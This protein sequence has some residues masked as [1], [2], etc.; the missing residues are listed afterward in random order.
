MGNGRKQRSNSHNRGGGTLTS[1]EERFEEDQ[2][3]FFV[4]AEIGGEPVEMTV[5]DYLKWRSTGE[6]PDEF[7]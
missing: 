2:P 4:K 6:L 5:S 7:R 1:L 3:A